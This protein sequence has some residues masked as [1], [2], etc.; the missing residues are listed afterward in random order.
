MLGHLILDKYR[1][2][3]EKQ[4]NE[5][6]LPTEITHSGQLQVV[7]FVGSTGKAA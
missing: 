3:A 7:C 5:Q 2:K 4:Q 6:T 1:L